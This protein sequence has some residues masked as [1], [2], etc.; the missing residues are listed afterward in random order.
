MPADVNIVDDDAAPVTGYAGGTP[1]RAHGPRA[2]EAP[3]A[4]EAEAGAALAD[5]D[6]DCV[7]L[8]PNRPGSSAGVLV[9]SDVLEACARAGHP[10]EACNPDAWISARAAHCIAVRHGLSLE[11]QVSVNVLAGRDGRPR[12]EIVGELHEEEASGLTRRAAY[13]YQVDARSG[14][15][16]AT[17]K[18]VSV[19]FHT[20]S[21]S[22]DTP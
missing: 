6:Q 5:T 19:M 1:A 3:P 8:N 15:L 14:D 17:S 9:G 18:G 10:A 20:A 12:F 2:V 16:R 13:R 11:A 4:P 7:A 22:T 21:T